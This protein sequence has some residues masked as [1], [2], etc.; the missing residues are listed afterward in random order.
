[1][2]HVLW[3]DDERAIDFLIDL[4]PTDDRDYHRMRR[5]GIWRKVF[6]IARDQTAN[7]GRWALGMLNRLEAGG[8]VYPDEQRPPSHY[9]ELRND[10]G[11]RDLMVEAVHKASGALPLM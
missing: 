7:T 11:F 3:L 6:G 8:F 5:R 9:R 2:N 10:R 1:M 4:L